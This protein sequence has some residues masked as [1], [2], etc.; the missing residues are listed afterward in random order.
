M[1]NRRLIFVCSAVLVFSRVSSAQTITASVTGTVTD[2]SGAIVP[3]VVIRATS[4]STSLVSTTKTNAAGLY[5]L[6]FLPIGDYRVTAEAQ[7]FKTATAGPI[8]LEVDQTSR[9]DFQMQLGDVSQSVDVGAA[10]SILQTESAQTG[11]VIG[12]TQASQLPLNGR[13]FMNLTLLVPGSITPQ[14][15]SFATPSRAFDGG[16]PYVN[17]NR[18]QSNNFLLDGV[19]INEPVG[20]F[21]GYNPNVDALAEVQVLTGNPSAEFGNAN[22]AIVNMTTKSGTNE[23]HGN[24]FEFLRN[25]ALDANDFFLNRTGQPKQALR[26]NQFGGTLGGP[27]HRNRTFFFLDYQGSRVRDSGSALATVI[28]APFRTGDLTALTGDFIDPT[29]GNPFPG[30]IIPQSRIANPAAKKLF[31]SPDLYPLPNVN[32]S[33]DNFTNNYANTTTD[34]SDN[35]QADVRVDHHIDDTNNVFGRFTVERYRDGTGKTTMPVVMSHGND[36]PTLSFVL[37]WTHTF[38]PSAVNEARMGYTRVVINNV[39]TDPSGKLSK[40]TD[41]TFGIPGGQ[42]IAGLS[43][44]SLPDVD[45][46]GDTGSNYSTVDNTYHYSDNFMKQ[47]GRH[48]LKIGANA[49]RYQENNSFAGGNGLLGQFV[50]DGTFSGSDFADFLLGDVAY[51]GRGSQ[52]GLWGQRQWRAGIFFQD[53]FKILPNLTFNL[54]LRWEYTQPL[55]EVANRQVNI[56]LTTGQ[57]LFA[58][59]DGNSRALYNP[60]YKQ[61]E[62]RIG[63]AWTPASLHNKFVLRAGYGITSY[64]EGT[65]AN[66]RLPLNPPYFFESA[67]SYDQSTGPGNIARGFTDVQPQNQLAGQVRAWDPN[68]RPAQIQQWNFSIEHQFTNSLSLTTAYVGQ[69]GTHLVDPRDYNQPLPGTGAPSSW[70]P[71]DERRPLY[72]QNP[73]LTDI[74]GTDSS[75]TMNYNSLQVSLR[76]RYSAGLELLAAYTLSKS[77]SDSLGYWGSGALKSEDSYWQNAYDRHADYGRSFFDARDNFSLGGTYDLPYGL[78]RSFGNQAGV[79]SNLI[80]GGWQAGFVVSAHTGF[81]VTV[82]STDE[83]LQEAAHGDGYARPNYYRPGSEQ[84]RSIDHWYGDMTVCT[85]P[86]VDDGTCSYG[87]PALGTFGNASKATEEAPGFLDTDLSVSKRFHLDEKRYVDFRTEFFNAFNHPDFK[88][89]TQDI[90]SPSFGAIHVTVGIPRTIQFGLKFY[91]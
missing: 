47:V 67:V 68:L 48:S 49:I 26:Q 39:T 91:F 27:I 57:A 37:G 78:G 36:A 20:N 61:F 81:P 17:G 23:F 29:T 54:G 5:N 89:P 87:V 70:L 65:G 90:T 45:P 77:L 4:T 56:D 63:V 10:G 50:F 31:S 43:L 30:N 19:D 76:K 1:L 33:L 21:V 55:Y 75:A 79:L 2:S 64:M 84:N 74:S 59:V 24:L 44:L 80:L 38:S 86:G 35:D 13:N 16:R 8:K 58:G 12:G 32:F 66:L 41:A 28:P 69:D 40:G 88:G 82:L 62:P 53:D 14:W 3:D 6:L 83:S 18:E 11:D 22:G 71:L 73:A 42:P 34:F 46:I 52:T 51:K 60:Y 15:Q 72:S 25:D 7:G 9:L 85:T